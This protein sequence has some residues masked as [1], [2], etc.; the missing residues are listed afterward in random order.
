[1]HVTIERT[2]CYSQINLVSAKINVVLDQCKL[3]NVY[4]RNI[5]S[6]CDPYLKINGN[7]DNMH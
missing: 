3:S 5:N 1:M 4:Y 6:Y 2:S 7:C